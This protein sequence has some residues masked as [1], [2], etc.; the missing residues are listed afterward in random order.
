VR[1][2]F[3][4]HFGYIQCQA[5][6]RLLLLYP[7]SLHEQKTCPSGRNGW[8]EW[9]GWVRAVRGTPVADDSV[10]SINTTRRVAYCPL[11]AVSPFLLALSVFHFK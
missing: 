11:I 3:F 8:A 4:G 9:M 7:T 2:A 5:H 6:V 10:P 1:I